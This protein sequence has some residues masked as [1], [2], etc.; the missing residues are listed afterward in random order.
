AS[1]GWTSPVHAAIYPPAEQRRA[2]HAAPACPEFGEDSVLSRPDRDTPGRDNVKPAGPGF[3]LSEHDYDV[4]G[5]DPGSLTLDVRRVYG[6]RR[7]DLIVEPDRAIVDA[8]RTRYDDWLAARQA[9]LDAG[10]RPSL[11]VTAVTEWA[12]SS[13]DGAAPVD[14]DVTLIDTMGGVA[15]ARPTGPRFGTLVHAALATV[16]LDA[17]PLQI[18]ETVSLQARILGSPEDEV[19]A[20]TALVA[21]ALAHPLIGRARDAWRAGRCRREAPLA[22]REPDGSLIEGV[23]DLAF[24]DADGW[25]VVD[26]KTDA[27]IAGELPRYRRQ[28]GLYASI[29]SRATGKGAKAVLLRL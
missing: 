11:R 17:L 12:R 3:G 2:S 14:D 25:T 10:A 24:E 18:T 9:A 28:V 1:D 5:W 13:P 22:C 6:L 19:H 7:E 16:A 4:V 15:A 29:I 23:V 26:F 20:A 8:G 21:A 27:E